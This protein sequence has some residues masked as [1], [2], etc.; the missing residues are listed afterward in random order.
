MLLTPIP[1][2]PTESP[3]TPSTIRRLPP[4]DRARHVPHH[5]S[6]SYAE[7][8]IVDQIGV[9]VGNYHPVV[10]FFILLGLSV[11]LWFLLFCAISAVLTAV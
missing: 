3:I 1:H 10:R 4:L 7:P 11:A 9:E 2:T 8:R 6:W 5:R